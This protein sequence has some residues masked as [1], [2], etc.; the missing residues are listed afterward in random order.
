ML[1]DDQ[2]AA[3]RNHHQDAEQSAED[4]HEHHARELEIEAE[5]Q[6]RRHRDADAECDRLACR[7]R[8]LNNVVFENRRVAQAEFRQDS[9][10]C[11]R[12]HGDRDRRADGQT[13]LQHKVE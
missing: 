2:R 12:N 10:K 11:D 8:G 6:D 1:R 3:Q 4:R 13:D 5:D 9:K 7:S